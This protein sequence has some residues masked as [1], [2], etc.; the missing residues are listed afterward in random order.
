M[1]GDYIK[2]VSDGTQL[3]IKDT[4]CFLYCNGKY[5]RPTIDQFVDLIKTGYADFLGEHIVGCHFESEGT[6]RN[7][8]NGT[9]IWDLEWCE[10]SE[11]YFKI[12]NESKEI[13]K[14]GREI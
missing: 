9:K 4:E 7:I 13:D 1:N 6:T 11:F 12:S 14:N 2:I 5:I 10:L 3:F 8:P